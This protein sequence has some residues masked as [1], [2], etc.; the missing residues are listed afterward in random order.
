[1][2]ES[3][4]IGAAAPEGETMIDTAVTRPAA[5]RAPVRPAVPVAVLAGVLNAA[6]AVVQLTAPA[7]PSGN[8]PFV[9]TTDYVIEILF[10]ASLVAAAAA[11]LLVGRWA[12]QSPRWG[13]F[14]TGVVAA[15]AFAPAL[16]AISSAVTAARGRESLDF[17]Q[18]PAVGIWL[19]AGLLMAVAVI[20]AR[21]LPVLVGLAFAVA[22]P[23]S[24]AL[25]NAGPLA[26]TALWIAVAVVLARRPVPATDPA[27]P[28]TD[29]AGPRS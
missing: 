7:Q 18:L 25:G 11:A 22:L 3:A 28:A 6:V 24:M 1:V 14:G 9:R 17:L 23:A 15:Y 19:I 4:A 16:F 20:R 27:V 8:R 5:V 21:V 12:R 29:P 26:L 13:R 2:E 10:A